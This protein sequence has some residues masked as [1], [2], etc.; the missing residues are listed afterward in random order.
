MMSPAGENMMKE[1]MLISRE[2]DDWEAG[3]PTL[4]GSR[5]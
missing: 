3:E 2:Q 5:G 1:L 4:V